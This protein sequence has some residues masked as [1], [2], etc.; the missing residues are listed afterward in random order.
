MVIH[1]QPERGGGRSKAATALALLATLL[2]SGPTQSRAFCVA[3]KTSKSSTAEVRIG[4]GASPGTDVTVEW[5]R[6][7]E[8]ARLDGAAIRLPPIRIVVS[9]T[10][11]A[12]HIV[13]VRGASIIELSEK[14]EP[15]GFADRFA[16]MNPHFHQTFNENTADKVLYKDF[17][18]IVSSKRKIAVFG[19]ANIRSGSIQRVNI[20]ALQRIVNDKPVPVDTLI[21]LYAAVKNLRIEYS[22]LENITGAYGR[23]PIAPGGGGEIWVRN[24]SS[25]GSRKENVS[26]NIIIRNNVFRHYTSDEALS[27]YGVRG[28]TRRVS[29]Y[30][31][32]FEGLMNLAGDNS[33]GPDGV[34]H[35]TFISF[36]PL[37]DGSGTKLG[38][39]AAV[40]D[41][42]FRDN[43]IVD[44]QF[45]HN[46]VRLGHT[47]ERNNELHDIRLRG[48]RISA[49]QSADPKRGALAAWIAAGSPGG[50]SPRRTSTILRNIAHRHVKGTSENSSTK[51]VLIALPGGQLIA[52][53][54]MGFRRIAGTV[55]IGRIGKRILRP[56]P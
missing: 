3:S 37:N 29:I 9:R 50:L 48:N 55:V 12:A 30:N 19:L 24:I 54:A 28:V 51:D 4:E 18:I 42:D 2:A 8:K 25:D 14:F 5:V 20:R 10:C 1:C 17:D 56:G 41:V 44:R 38:D 22:V 7:C 33:A 32:R 52:T 21:D 47:P 31:N 34:Y 40:Y 36:F 27:V 46:V 11:T 15:S 49:F 26:E 43:I 53:G 23:S 39:K 13:G 45:L 16:I 35:V 6:A